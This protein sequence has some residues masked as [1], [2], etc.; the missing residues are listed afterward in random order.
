MEPVP[1]DPATASMLFRHEASYH[2]GM[3]SESET[4][5]TLQDAEQ[6][7]AVAGQFVQDGR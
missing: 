3:V 1:R 5:T 7:L 4:E 2:L 6:L